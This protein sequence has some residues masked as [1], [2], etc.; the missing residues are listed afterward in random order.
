MEPGRRNNQRREPSDSGA[1]SGRGPT[2]EAL[3]P[4]LMLSAHSDPTAIVVPYF[5]MGQWDFF[6]LKDLNG[7]AEFGG[8]GTWD[9]LGIGGHFGSELV[10]AACLERLPSK[11]QLLSKSLGGSALDFLETRLDVGIVQHPLAEVLELRHDLPVGGKLE[12]DVLAEILAELVLIV[13]GDDAGIV[14]KS[15]EDPRAG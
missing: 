8:G 12:S 2:F 5:D 6:L 13:K 14:H 15:G 11:G 3:Q 4:R 7:Q 10:N 9:P 1:V